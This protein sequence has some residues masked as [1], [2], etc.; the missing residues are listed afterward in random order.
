MPYKH[1]RKVCSH[2]GKDFLIRTSHQQFCSKSCSNSG[3]PKVPQKTYPARLCAY[4]GSSFVSRAPATHFC[5]M[6]CVAFARYGTETERFWG[7]VRK[8]DGCWLWTGAVG[9]SGYGQLLIA[10]R[11]VGAHRYSYAMVNGPIPGAMEV[12]HK[13]D[14]PPC[15]NPAHLFLG[16]QAENIQ[17]MFNKGRARPGGHALKPRPR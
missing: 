15:V 1:I 2:C 16:T 7:R 11:L 4:C 14:T 17:D 10:G 12:L 13:C 3:R 6:A 9:D 5:S 8:T